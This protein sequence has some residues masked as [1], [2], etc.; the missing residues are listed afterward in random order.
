MLKM[1]YVRSPHQ[2]TRDLPVASIS[3]LSDLPRKFRKLAEL[4]GIL[5]K[6]HGVDRNRL[7]DFR[8][9]FVNYAIDLLKKLVVTWF[10]RD[11]SD[12]C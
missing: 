12:V 10:E 2:I 11:I 5:R 4:F 3:G 9:M 8:K 1:H 7:D 6:C